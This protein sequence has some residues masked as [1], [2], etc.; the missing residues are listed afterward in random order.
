MQAEGE[1]M[2][3]RSAIVL[4]QLGDRLSLT[5]CMR[6]GALKQPNVE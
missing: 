5:S 6:R 1:G 3:L 2:Q 4:D